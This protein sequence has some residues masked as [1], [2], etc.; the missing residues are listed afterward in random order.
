MPFLIA[1]VVYVVL[2]GLA[3]IPVAIGL[4]RG[5]R[6]SMTVVA[7]TIGSVVGFMMG[8]AGVLVAILV[9][10]GDQVGATL[11]VT[12]FGLSVSVVGAIIAV[13]TYWIYAIYNWSMAMY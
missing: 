7:A 5:R 4:A 10:A 8:C 12:S 1:C 2:A 3:L 9:G 6:P 13:I 11:I